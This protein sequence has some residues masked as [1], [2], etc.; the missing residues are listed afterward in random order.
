[1]DNHPLA[2]QMHYRGS[3]IPVLMKTT[4]ALNFLLLAAFYMLVI[5]L[6]LFR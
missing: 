3:Q 2:Q 6:A 4:I 1:V 5:V